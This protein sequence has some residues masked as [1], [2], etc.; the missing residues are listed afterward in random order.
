MGPHPRGVPACSV[1]NKR[2]LPLKP[3]CSTSQPTTSTTIQL[4]PQHQV[5]YGG[6][7]AS[8]DRLHWVYPD[9]YAV[10]AA[11]LLVS[12]LNGAGRL[13]FEADAGA[14][15]PLFSTDYTFSKGA[16]VLR[17]P[18]S[19]I[20]PHTHSLP[21]MPGWSPPPPPPSS[22][23]PHI[24]CHSCLAAA[25]PHTHPPPY[26]PGCR[27]RAHAGRAGLSGP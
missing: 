4:S 15:N 12:Q 18:G 1:A 26:M 10:R 2:P 21:F 14:A 16:C 3:C 6:R 25:P 23:T 19:W 9:A 8:C 5:R 20:P 11:E 27:P 13:D 24:P 7:C 22:P 17:D